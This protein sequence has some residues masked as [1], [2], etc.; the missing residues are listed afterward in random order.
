MVV[1]GAQGVMENCEQISTLAALLRDYKEYA[2]MAVLVG[3]LVTA[4]T[5]LWIEN[6]KK[7]NAILELALTSQS[8]RLKTAEAIREM[9]HVLAS[10]WSEKKEGRG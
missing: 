7:E 1:L 10:M 9:K 4:I 3:V 8:A 2:V 5:K 6:K